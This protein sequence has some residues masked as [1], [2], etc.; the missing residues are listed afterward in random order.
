[1]LENVNTIKLHRVQESDL[2]DLFAL[3]A[4]IEVVKFTNWV[5]LQREEEARHR[6]E[7]VRARYAESEDRIGP[8]VIR[9]EDG[10]FV[11]LIGVDYVEQAHELWYLLC[12][13]QWG[14]GYGTAA[15]VNLLE[16]IAGHPRVRTLVA[17]AVAENVASWRL[18]ERTGFSRVGVLPLAF[19]KNGQARDLFK[20][21]R[22]GK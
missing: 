22:P 13:S 4:D 3:W 7:R 6:L 9:R 10:E 18:L 8:F 2:S 15:V 11:G 19:Q 12:R 14:R 21:E 1:M 5:L 20:Y 17:T 16:R